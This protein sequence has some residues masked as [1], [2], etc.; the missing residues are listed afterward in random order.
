MGFHLLS[1]GLNTLPNRSCRLKLSLGPLALFSCTVL[2]KGLIC[3]ELKEQGT[4]SIDNLSLNSP[5]RE[6][7]A[8]GYWQ[9]RPAPLRVH[10]RSRTLTPQLKF[11]GS[12]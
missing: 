6:L 12:S 11:P 10:A 5:D 8:L 4:N 2:I 1:I 3:K 7:G 9:E